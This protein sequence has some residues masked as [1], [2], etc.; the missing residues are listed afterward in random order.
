[1]HDDEPEGDGDA[2]DDE[3][4]VREK[5]IN[6]TSYEKTASPDIRAC[7]PARDAVVRLGCGGGSGVEQGCDIP[8]L[9]A[10]ALY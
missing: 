1:M 9:H 8:Q 2:G 6:T 5:H 10:N 3:A 4:V 7:H